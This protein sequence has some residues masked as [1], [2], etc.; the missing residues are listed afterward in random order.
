MFIVILK[1]HFHLSGTL[2]C[3]FCFKFWHTFV[4]IILPFMNTFLMDW[5][6]TDKEDSVTSFTTVSY[7]HLDVYK[8]QSPHGAHQPHFFTNM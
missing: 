4:D 5:P 7:T 6:H 8:R 2:K 3:F 1:S